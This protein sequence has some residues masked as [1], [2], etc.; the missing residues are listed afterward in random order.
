[1]EALGRPVFCFVDSDRAGDGQPPS[2]QAREFAER[3]RDV[4][5]VHI[6]DRRSIENYLSSEALSSALGKD[7]TV[8]LGHYE[9]P[10]SA[11]I[12]FSKRTHVERAA[13]EMPAGAIPKEIIDFLGAV[14]TRSRTD[15]R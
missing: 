15:V 5:H 11:D 14:R 13:G 1:M 4:A 12:E 9:T 3:L 7:V 6:S 8:D 2:D 10:D